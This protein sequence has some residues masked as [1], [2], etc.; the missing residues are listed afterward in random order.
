MEQNLEAL[1]TLEKGK[2]MEK[3]QKNMVLIMLLLVISTENIWNW[4]QVFRQGLKWKT[5]EK[6]SI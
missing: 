6:I 2:T 3:G 5:G 1:Q 4:R